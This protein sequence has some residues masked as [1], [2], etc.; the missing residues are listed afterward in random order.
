MYDSYR[1]KR[2]IESLKRRLQRKSYPRL[3]ASIILLLT[4]LAGF[5]VSFVLLRA[6]VTAMWL[7]YP[8]AILVAYGVFL[9]LLRVW[10]SLSRPRDWN[11]EEVVDTTLEVVTESA[12]SDD[13]GFG[14]G[15]DFAGGGAGGAW[16]ESVSTITTTRSSV[17]TFT[18]SKS[19]GSSGFSFDL[20]LDDGWWI[21]LA[22]IALLGAAIA[23]LYV[24]YIA[25]ALL[26][27]IL[28]DGVL[29]AGLYERVKS[30]EHEHWLRSALRR[31]AVPAIIIV[32]FFTIAGYAMHRIAPDAHSIGG[33]WTH[34]TRDSN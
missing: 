8:V 13:P 3:H 28:L 26:A 4:G 11:L 24:V 18:S 27:E 22:I 20:D 9:I 12:E 2:K 25:P 15:A 10:L 6:G 16:G 14:G 31:T 21:L 30:I 34:I 29:L 19:S 33:V 7:R 5:L 23:A 17:S 1:R 32:V